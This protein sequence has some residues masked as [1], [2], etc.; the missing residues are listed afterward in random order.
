MGNI[1]LYKKHWKKQLK[2]TIEYLKKK[3]ES[4]WRDWERECNAWSWKY[5]AWGKGIKSRRC[6]HKWLGLWYWWQC[7]WW[8]WWLFVTLN[9]WIKFSLFKWLLLFWPWDYT[10]G[11]SK[12]YMKFILRFSFFWICNIFI[13]N[14]VCRDA[15]KHNVYLVPQETTDF[16]PFPL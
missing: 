8:Q 7:R 5:I 9:L 3:L 10:N 2:M 11:C 6:T 1:L 4:R 16:H 12:L 15:Q 13:S 14:N